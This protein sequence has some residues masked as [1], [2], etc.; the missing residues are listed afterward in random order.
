MLTADRGE[1]ETFVR[2][3]FASAAP[4]GDIELRS[5]Y[6][7]TKDRR[8]FQRKKVSVADLSTVID[9]AVDMIDRAAAAPNGVVFCPPVCTFRPGATRATEADVFE[10]LAVSV[11]LDRDPAAALKILEDVLGAASL[12]VASGGQ[13][14]NE[15]TKTDDPK[16]HAYWVLDL[17]AR[18]P[19]ELAHL[20][21]ARRLACSIAGAD[22]TNVPLVHPIRWPGSWHRKK[23]DAPRL[24]RIVQHE[25][26]RYSLEKLVKSLEAAAARRGVVVR[27]AGL[28]ERTDDRETRD[29]IRNIATGAEFHPSMTPLAMRLAVQ[30][31]PKTI[32]ESVLQGLMMSAG[33][34]SDARWS[35]RYAEVPQI[36]ASAYAKL[37][38][39]NAPGWKLRLDRSQSSGN[40][41]TDWKNILLAFKEA[42]ALAGKL[43][44]NTR[45]RVLEVHERLPWERADAH[46][47]PRPWTDT[48]IA[49]ACVWLNNEGFLKVK[50]NDVWR[51]AQLAGQFQAY[52]PLLRYLEA[53]QWDGVPRLDTW[54]S[55]YCGARIDT[56]QRRA[57]VAEVGARWMLQ[58]VSRAF[59][60]GAKADCVLILEGPQGVRKS[61]ALAV[62]GGP[63]YTEL[64]ADIAHDKR[65]VAMSLNG[66][67]IIEVS[68]L[69]ALRKADIA[70]IKAFFSQTS[71]RY[72]MPYEKT[73]E[74]HPRGVVFA[75]TMNPDGLEYLHD[76]TGNRRFWP[77]EVAATGGNI[78]TD[79]LLLARDQMWAEAVARFRRGERTWLQGVEIEAAAVEEQALRTV[80]V[81]DD[82]WFESVK[83]WVERSGVELTTVHEAMNLAL[84]IP[85]ER[86]DRGRQMRVARILRALGFV[87]KHTQMGKKWVLTL[88]E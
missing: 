63:F 15:T 82:P 46:P 32:T 38:F 39:D 66:P 67:W 65:D 73:I 72:R 59:R 68:E 83:T 51:V 10:G 2:T 17:P 5:F 11:E 60:P 18:T 79:G 3:V 56:P 40:I 29:L 71:D 9:A 47:H 81:D 70:R 34:P 36:V 76:T 4:G 58:A 87:K 61:T 23:I 42:P 27:A 1:L 69:D 74:D 43:R 85:A 19:D 13:W 52:D 8:Q 12:V 57:Y 24:C 30:G 16:L 84:A 50:H 22:A 7:A 54:L 78:D 44:L 41:S 75:G 53:V 21:Y 20:K 28:G 37:D 77:V 48:D 26:A 6:D 33:G 88:F 49:A 80:G 64:T 31:V 35:A 55:T 45:A 62:L 86:Q 14:H 25:N